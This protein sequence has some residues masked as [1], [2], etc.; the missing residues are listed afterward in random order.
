MQTPVSASVLQNKLSH[1]S[2]KYPSLTSGIPLPRHSSPNSTLVH[3][4]SRQT[5]AQQEFE[6]INNLH[7]NLEFEPRCK[8]GDYS[9]DDSSNLSGEQKISMILSM[10]LEINVFEK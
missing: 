10:F 7:S 9:S 8:K 1:S 2:Y 5:L 6:A 3:G 4:I